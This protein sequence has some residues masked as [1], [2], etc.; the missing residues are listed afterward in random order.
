MQPKPVHVCEKRIKVGMESDLQP[1][2]LITYKAIPACGGQVRLQEKE[3]L[4][5]KRL[6]ASLL[7]KKQSLT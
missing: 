5:S 1:G 2:S 7:I 4:K 3:G 6:T